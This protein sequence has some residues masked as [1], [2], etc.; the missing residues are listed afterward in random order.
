MDI[1]T[2][3]GTAGVIDWMDRTLYPCYPSNWDNSLFRDEI[4]RRIQSDTRILD[5]GAGAGIVSEMNFRGLAARVSGIDPDERVLT[6]PYLDEARVARGEEIPYPDSSFDLVLANNVL[7]HVE[8]PGPLF[9]EVC[10]V[11]R[12]GGVFFAKTPNRTHYMP[13]LAMCTPHSFHTLVNRLRG[14]NSTD[15]FPTRYRVNTPAAIRRV[16]AKSGLQVMDIKLVEGRPEYLRFSPLTYLADIY[17][18]DGS[19]ACRG[20]SASGS[21]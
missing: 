2:K 12:T 8:V 13:L 18:S 17:T 1:S 4:V 3:S 19:I 5:V 10:R 9:K 11:M 7:E 20:L 15:T 16:A 6:N 14:R 21:S